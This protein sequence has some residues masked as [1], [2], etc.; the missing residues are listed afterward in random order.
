MTERLEKQK[1]VLKFAEHSELTGTDLTINQMSTDQILDKASSLQQEDIAA[2]EKMIQTTEEDIRIGVD[3]GVA[4]QQQNDQLR[5]ADANVKAI[6]ED[7][8]AARAQLRKIA[9][10]LASDK[11]LLCLACFLILLIAVAII[12]ASTA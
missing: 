8:R 10:R 2:L 5:N 1:T 9:N 11:L 4:I 3:T 12:V 7:L 6:D